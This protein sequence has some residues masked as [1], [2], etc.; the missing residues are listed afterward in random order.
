[1]Q[2]FTSAYQ[3]VKFLQYLLE[4]LLK[5]AIGVDFLL[6]K[7]RGGELFLRSLVVV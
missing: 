3:I 7:F 6:S 1:M 5:G 2:Y 4:E